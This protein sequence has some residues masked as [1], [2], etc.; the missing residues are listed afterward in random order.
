VVSDYGVIT[1]LRTLHKVAEDP[2]KASAPA[3]RAGVDVELPVSIPAALERGLITIPKR[4]WMR[5]C[6]G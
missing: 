3:L 1:L 5:Q 6:A 2:A 4:T